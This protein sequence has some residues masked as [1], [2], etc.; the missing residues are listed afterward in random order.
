MSNTI[1]KITIGFLEDKLSWI[2]IPNAIEIY[3]S[4]D[5]QLFSI[6]EKIDATHI[7]LNKRNAVAEL[8]KNVARYVKIKINNYGIIP[9]YNPG[10]GN[11]SWLFVDEISIE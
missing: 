4:E 5:G 11:K 10:A 7:Q 8:N 9:P 3:T 2:W 1:S 6:V